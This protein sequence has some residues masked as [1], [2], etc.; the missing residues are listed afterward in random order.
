MMPRRQSHPASRSSARK[1]LPLK[2]A[3]AQL[4]R[5]TILRL[6][7][8]VVKTAFHQC[9]KGHTFADGEPANFAQQRIGNFDGN[10]QGLPL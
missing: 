1:P 9:S 3:Q 4:E 7:N 2:L 5:R 8:H 6:R 10:L